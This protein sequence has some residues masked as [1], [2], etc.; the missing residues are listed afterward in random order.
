M[1]KYL[2]NTNLIMNLE[3]KIKVYEPNRNAKLGFAIWNEMFSEL[4]QSRELIMRFAIRDIIANYKQSI[5]GVLWIFILPLF[6]VAT[7]VY[8][9]YSGVFNIGETNIP[10]PAYALL[11]VTIWQ[12]F[13]TGITTC[14]TSLT[15][16][17][18]LITKINFA[19]ESMIFSSLARTIFDFLIRVILLAGVFAIYKIVP[20]WTII[21]LP[22]AIV[23]ILLLTLGL[24]FIVAVLNGVFRDTAHIV[25]IATTFLMFVTP[26]LY[27]PPAMEPVA[28]LNKIN[29]IGI[30]VIGARDIMISGSLTQPNEFVFA[31][32]FSIFFFL[33]S[34]RAFHM[35]EPR[36]AERV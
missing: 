31:S 24:G 23:P 7:F 36:I 32:I 33:F 17:G 26:V 27:P 28:T 14:T 34:W 22:L 6:T 8:L 2:H 15:L 5:L 3:K 20:S 10:Y 13:G 11:G 25:S 4:I 12:I 9:N 18:N 30:L 1:K 29:P 19:K 21:F 16:S 35:M